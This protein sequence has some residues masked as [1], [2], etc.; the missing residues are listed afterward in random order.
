MHKRQ[1]IRSKH[2][3]PREGIETPVCFVRVVI[4][5]RVVQNTKIPVRGLKLIHIDLAVDVDYS[6]QNTKI[7][8]RGLKCHRRG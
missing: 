6:V 8:V 5:E 7:P 3:N 4:R 1:L 2:Q